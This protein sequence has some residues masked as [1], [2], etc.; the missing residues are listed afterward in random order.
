MN[1]HLERLVAILD[2]LKQRDKHPLFPFVGAWSPKLTD[3]AGEKFKVVAE[4]HRQIISVLRKDWLQPELVQTA[5]YYQ[6]ISA[7]Q[8]EYNYPL[9]I[10][11]LNYDLCLE[12]TC[13]DTEVER[14]FDEQRV[15]SWSRFDRDEN[16]DVA[17][18]LYK[19]HGSVDWKY[20][21]GGNL[22]Y[23]DNPHRIEGQGALIFGTSYKLQYLDPFLFC[24]YELRRWTL[25]PDAHLIVCVGY[26]FE[27]EHI[28]ATGVCT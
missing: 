4:F 8:Q 20:D 10:F 23:I 27:D 28:N 15:W 16:S 9:R 12:Q 13:Q 7:F 2:E 3:V 19:L 22:T 21:D 26:G 11:S 25:D 17:I 5:E 14:G 6:G 18:Y 1:T 24:I